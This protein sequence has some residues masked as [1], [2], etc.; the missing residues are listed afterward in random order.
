MNKSVNLSFVKI[1]LLVET[2]VSALFIILFTLTL[3]KDDTKIPAFITPFSVL[4][5]RDPKLNTNNLFESVNNMEAVKLLRDNQVLNASDLCYKLLKS[6]PYDI[7]ILLSSAQVFFATGN[8]DKGLELLLEAVKLAPNNKFIRLY[9]GEGLLLS[10][11]YLDS[12]NVFNNLFLSKEVKSVYL[13]IELSRNYIQLKNYKQAFDILEKANLIFP[14]NKDVEYLLTFLQSK[15]DENKEG[16]AEF[17]KIYEQNYVLSPKIVELL[18][19]DGSQPK[20]VLKALIDDAKAS[21]GEI[22]LITEAINYAIFIKQFKHAL[23]LVKMLPQKPSYI[24]D[25][26]NSIIYLSLQKPDLAYQSFK[27]A[28]DNYLDQ[29]PKWNIPSNNVLKYF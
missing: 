21:Q 22:D 16:L 8:Q 25:L 3:P 20:L 5:S 4:N 1:P 12:L 14:N 9:Y 2:S 10:G 15:L 6:N 23:E 19:A 17:K 18:K 13:Y 27:S 7:K 28:S 26:Y 24:C 29:K 11:K